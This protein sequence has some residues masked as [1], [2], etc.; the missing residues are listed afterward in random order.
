VA[1]GRQEASEEEEKEEEEKEEEK[2]A[3]LPIDTAHVDFKVDKESLFK[4]LEPVLVCFFAHGLS[5]AHSR[6]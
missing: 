5:F 6:S 4:L 1:N 2:E 3:E